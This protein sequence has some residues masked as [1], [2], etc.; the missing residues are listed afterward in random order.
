MKEAVVLSYV[1][2]RHNEWKLRLKKK[3]P[4]YAMKAYGCSR[5]LGTLIFN[6]GGTWD[7]GDNCVC[8]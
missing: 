4:F 3:A 6:R 2:M 7:G 8:Y 5:G 1:M